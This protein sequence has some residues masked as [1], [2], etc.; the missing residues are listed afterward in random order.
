MGNPRVVESDAETFGYKAKLGSGSSSGSETNVGG[1]QG[2]KFYVY[3][4]GQLPELALLTSRNHGRK[5]MCKVWATC[6]VGS[7]AAFSFETFERLAQVNLP[8]A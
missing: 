6:W 2:L 8:P 7:V 1:L 3:D 5:G 4:V